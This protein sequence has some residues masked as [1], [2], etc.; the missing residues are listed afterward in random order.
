[1]PALA[2]LQHAP[3]RDFNDPMR[4]LRLPLAAAC[5]AALTGCASTIQLNSLSRPTTPGQTITVQDFRYNEPQND[6]SSMGLKGGVYT[7]ELENSEG[8]FYRC[9]GTCAKIPAVS[10]LNKQGFPDSVFPGGLFVYKDGINKPPRIYYYQ[11]NLGPTAGEVDPLLTQQIGQNALPNVS[12]GG[13]V[14]GGALSGAVIGAIIESGRG[15][16]LLIPSTSD[17]DIRKFVSRN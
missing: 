17:I 3:T 5:L 1:M 7:V 6:A 2:D 8:Y 11:L 15:Q 4:T 12:A 14:L 9:P 10:N 16:I 13:G